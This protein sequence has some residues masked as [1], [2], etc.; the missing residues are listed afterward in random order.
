M[1]IFKTAIETPLKATIAIASVVMS[2][3][4]M[5]AKVAHRLTDLKD[6]TAP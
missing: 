6:S 5:V 3:A 1:T 4:V 2:L